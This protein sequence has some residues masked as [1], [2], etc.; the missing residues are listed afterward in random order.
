L[1]VT[2]PGWPIR[3]SVMPY[4]PTTSRCFTVFTVGLMMPMNRYLTMTLPDK[5]AQTRDSG[6]AAAPF[7][8][9][10]LRACPA[11]LDPIRLQ[12]VMF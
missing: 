1:Y 7:W 12:M 8:Q 3:Q 9:A 6:T 5:F 4:N 11:T 2:V 10:L